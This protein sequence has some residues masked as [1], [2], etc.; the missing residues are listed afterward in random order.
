MLLKKNVCYLFNK[1]YNKQ[2]GVFT[3]NEFR[4]SAILLKRVV[5][6]PSEKYL[7]LK[8]FLSSPKGIGGVFPSSNYLAK[9]MIR[10]LDIDSCPNIAE[11]GVGTGSLTRYIF[12]YMNPYTK[13]YLFEKDPVFLNYLNKK[14]QFDN[15]CNIKTFSDA[16]KIREVF[17]NMEG[18]NPDMIVSGLPFANFEQ[19]T[20]KKFLKDIHETLRPNGLFIAYQYSLG[21]YKELKEMYSEVE[22]DFV[23]F[24][25]PPAIIYRCKK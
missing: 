19:K 3:Y 23:F 16:L 10:Q 1:A 25:I 17:K 11:L 12:K 20:R 13:M 24:N 2:T 8:R 22:L 14:Y 15:N 21:I 6:T 7:F 5:S 4:R 18:V 9:K